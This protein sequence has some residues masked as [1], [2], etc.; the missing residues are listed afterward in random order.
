MTDQ[1]LERLRVA[2]VATHS[3][4]ALKPDALSEVDF[5]DGLLAITSGHLF[6]IAPYRYAFDIREGSSGDDAHMELSAPALDAEHD[7]GGIRQ[8]LE[9]QFGNGVVEV[10]E[11]LAPSRNGTTTLTNRG[12]TLVEVLAGATQA[13]LRQEAPT[14]RAVIDAEFAVAAARMTAE[15]LDALVLEGVRSGPLAHRLEAIE[16]RV[17]MIAERTDLMAAQPVTVPG[18]DRVLERLSRIESGLLSLFERA[19]TRPEPEAAIPEPDPMVA[20]RF[21][22]LGL[23]IGELSERISGMTTQPEES[24]RQITDAIDPV[25]AR[26]EA[27]ITDLEAVTARLDS[28]L[29]EREFQ[30]D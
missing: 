19:E 6:R 5:L 23:L 27:R 28:V 3:V 21:D 16:E 26:L 20:E 18:F 22:R 29:T 30:E 24:N 25:V 12:I 13:A 2:E 9:R 7:A 11:I 4:A 1:M 10:E 15:G 14:C 17:S 8:A